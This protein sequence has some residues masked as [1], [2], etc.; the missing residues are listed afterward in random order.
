M[1]TVTSLWDLLRHM[2]GDISTNLLC[3]KLKKGPPD[4][5]CIKSLLGVIQPVDLCPPALPKIL[6]KAVT[7]EDV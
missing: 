4:I 5:L 2:S 1:A 3:Q 6:A 7:F